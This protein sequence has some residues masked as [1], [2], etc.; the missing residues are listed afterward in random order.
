MT[1]GKGPSVHAS[2]VLVGNRAGPLGADG[3]ATVAGARF[4]VRLPTP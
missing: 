3:E 2:A 1:P 4:V